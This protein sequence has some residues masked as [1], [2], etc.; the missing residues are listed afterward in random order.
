MVGDGW[1]WWGGWWS[2]HRIASTD[3][4]PTSIKSTPQQA[5]KSMGTTQGTSHG[6]WDGVKLRNAC[7][8]VRIRCRSCR[9]KCRTVPMTFQAPLNWRAESLRALKPAIP[10]LN[11]TAMS[12][13]S[14]G[15]SPYVSGALVTGMG[16]GR[17]TG[18]RAR[19]IVEARQ[20]G[21]STSAHA[22]APGP[23]GKY[24]ALCRPRK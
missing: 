7:K 17:G 4:H 9:T 8:M 2:Q 14:C 5:Y 19:S 20:P 15:H 13:V 18:G 1:W 10:L 22:A 11:A 24:R 3:Q 6:A 23:S 21:A 16:W 12:P